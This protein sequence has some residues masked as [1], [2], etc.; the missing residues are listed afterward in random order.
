[1]QLIAPKAGPDP[2]ELLTN[3]QNPRG[4]HAAPSD[5]NPARTHVAWCA[6]FIPMINPMTADKL[7]SLRQPL[8][9]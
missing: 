8:T 6:R 7:L 1:M 2:T 9:L 4:V 5:T 3:V